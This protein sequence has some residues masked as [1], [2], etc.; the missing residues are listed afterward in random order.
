MKSII[1][2]LLFPLMVQGQMIEK[3]W[4]TDRVLKT[5]ESVLYSTQTNM[6]YVSNINGK[7]TEKD[8]NGFITLMDTTGRIVTLKW[9]TGM[10]APKGMAI[11]R[12]TLFVSDID[13][14]HLVSLTDAKILKTIPV[15]GARFLNDVIVDE[16][17]AVYIT[18][19]QENKI[20]RMVNDSVEDWLENDLLEA[21]NGLALFRDGNLAVGVKNSVLKVFISSKNVKT[22]VDE[23]G[24]VDGIVRME[25]SKFI[26]SNWAGRVLL[27]SPSEKIVLYNKTEENKQTAD[28]GYIPDKKT[29]LVPTF[30]DN[31]V[32]AV[33]IVKIKKDL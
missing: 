13:R 22:F 16:F 11:Y 3:V 5:P 15:P 19:T 26:I 29:V 6:I 23:T 27:A 12:D 7:P 33:R 17:G 10:N 20:F 9:V 14:V 31:R 21:P 8:N 24:P 28:L 1:L 32:V 30:Y 18:D 25:G 4:S 2:I